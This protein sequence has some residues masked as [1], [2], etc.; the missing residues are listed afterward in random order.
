MVLSSGQEGNNNA[1]FYVGTNAGKWD[2]GIQ[3]TGW[4]LGTIPVE[5]KW[6]F[7]EVKMTGSEA[8]LYVDGVLT[9]RVSHGSY[10]LNKNFQ[11]GVHDSTA[12]SFSGSVAELRIESSG[13]KTGYYQFNELEGPL[14]FDHSGCGNDGVWNGA[15]AATE[16]QTIA[17]EKEGKF[18]KGVLVEPDTVNLAP[19]SDYEGRTYG[20]T[21]NASSWDTDAATVT[22]YSSGGY[23][24]MAYKKLI[25]NA[26]GTGGSY[27]DDHS[28]FPLEDG[29]TYTVSAWMKAS[30]AVELNGYAI[31]LNRGTDNKYIASGNY[32]L[33]TEWQRFSYTFTTAT[34]DAGDWRNRSIVYI[35][36]ALPIEIYWC[37]FQVEERDYPTSF[38]K[39]ARPLGRL[40]YPKELIEP[41][42]FTISCWFN[43]P[44][45]HRRNETNEGVSGNWYHPI[46][47]IAGETTTAGQS[48]GLVA[49]PEP[50]TFLRKLQLQ[51][52]GASISD[53]QVEDDTWY[54]MTTTYDGTVYKVYV[55]GV[56]RISYVGGAIAMADGQ[57]ISIGG[58]YRG[59]AFIKVDELRIESRAISAEEA[60]AWA[61][62]GLHYNYL[63]Y[64]LY[65]D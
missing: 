32:S 40:W 52:P 30:D 38:T 61:A 11:V 59:K 60:A 18:R 45:M 41:G 64:S 50:S 21:Y 55:D 39:D 15:V 28:S 53:F 44:Y 35:D 20:T 9:R 1:R 43:I 65:V 24:N 58:G 51:V 27:L 14:A 10:A 26:A 47:E 17:Q 23:N 25:K 36:E 31:A 48:F 7:I 8:S 42:A 19:F 56:E 4:G 5:M 49:G 33:T 13:E 16:G 2:M 62:S 46:V 29:K 12:Y 3:S 22:Y 34:G 37:G 57:Y 54:H 6:V 63:D